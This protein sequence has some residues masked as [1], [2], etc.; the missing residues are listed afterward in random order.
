[1]I[2]RFDYLRQHPPLCVKMT[3]LRLNEFA[4]LLDDLL[5]RFTTAAQR[6]RHRATRLRAVGGGRHTDLAPRDQLLLTSI[7]L[8]QYPTNEV[9][10]FLFGVSDSTAARVLSRIIP[11]LDAAGKD[12]M[13][14]PD[15]GRKRRKELSTLLAD[16]PE[17]AVIIDTFEQRVHRT[18]DRAHADTYAQR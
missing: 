13:R 3:G 12:T 15:P 4:D 11:L 9:L 6:R 17:L 10:G 16:T 1:M 8:R 18:K 5:P 14:L 7:W 2:C